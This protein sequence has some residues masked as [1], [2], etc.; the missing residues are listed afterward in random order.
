MRIAFFIHG[1]P[2]WDCYGA[3]NHVE[4][5]STYL[6]DRGNEV[7]VITVGRSNLPKVEQPRPH[8]T[9]YRTGYAD[10]RSQRLRPYWSFASYT[11]ATLVESVRLIRDKD[12]QVLHGHTIQWGGLQCI[13]ASRITGKPCILTVH[14]SG[15]D[16]YQSRKIPMHI[17]FLRWAKLIICQKTSAINKLLSW[18]LPEDKMTLLTEGFVDTRK[19]RPAKSRPRRNG[20]IVTFVGRLIPFKGP[21]LLVEAIPHILSKCPRTFFQFV[22]DGELR[23]PLDARTRSLGIDAN[24]KFLGFRRDVNEIMRDSNVSTSLSP[25]ENYTDFALLEAMATGVPVVATD[26]GETRTIVKDGETGLLAE[27]TPEDIARKIV[28][29]LTNKQLAYK[30]SKNER[31]LVVRQYSLDLGGK[32]HEEIYRSIVQ[33]NVSSSFP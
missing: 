17:R 32:K 28:E 33:R 20:P 6:A 29:V 22:G 25:Y 2:P 23:E 5:L 8:L 1:F 26:V 3:P 31:D 21:Q 18:G 19:F 30:L 15:L 12:I 7:Y 14:G 4:R 24:V 9:I 11:L 27:C 10:I 13:L 16:R